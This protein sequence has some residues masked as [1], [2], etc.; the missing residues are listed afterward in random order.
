MSVRRVGR[1]RVSSRNS[2]S[3]KNNCNYK[4]NLTSPAVFVLSEKKLLRSDI[5]KNIEIMISKNGKRVKH[6]VSTRKV[7]SKQLQ[8]SITDM[9]QKNVYNKSKPNYNRVDKN[10][11]NYK[12]KTSKLKRK[13]SKN[14]IAECNNSNTVRRTMLRKKKKISNRKGAENDGQR[15]LNASG[16]VNVR[17][18]KGKHCSMTSE[19]FQK[20]IDEMHLRNLNSI[21]LSNLVNVGNRIVHIS[22]EKTDFVLPSL[23]RHYEETWKKEDEKFIKKYGLAALNGVTRATTSPNHNNNSLIV[24]ANAV[25][26]NNVVNDED[27]DDDSTAVA[28]AFKSTCIEIKKLEAQ[29]KKIIDEIV[30]ISVVHQLSNKIRQSAENILNKLANNVLHKKSKGIIEKKDNRKKKNY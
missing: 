27:H 5:K 3:N 19:Q 6:T 10:S 11:S 1:I 8:N 13:R 7:R 14:D 4:N 26:P 20:Y 30:D 28:D 25:V 12:N 23:G 16:R 21:D 22:N 24:N 29:N 9:G 15:S 17:T 18:K 2:V